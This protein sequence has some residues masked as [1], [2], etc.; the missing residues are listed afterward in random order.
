VLEPELF[1]TTTYSVGEVRVRGLRASYCGT[2]CMTSDNQGDPAFGG[3]ALIVARGGLDALC[4]MPLGGEM[5]A[6]IRQAR[7]FDAATAEFHG[8]F[9]SRRNYDVLRAR[10]TRGEWHCGVLEQSWRIGGASGA[11]VA[12]LE[13]FEADP[14]LAAVRACS[15]EVYG[16]AP[17]PRGAIKHFDGIDARVGRLTKYTVVEAYEPA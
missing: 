7:A 16:G 1:E 15:T 12:A 3:S 6:A 13:A 14:A 9:A 4:A 8:L 2:Q 17:L 10:D 11:E 5:Q